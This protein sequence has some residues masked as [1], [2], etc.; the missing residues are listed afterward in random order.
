MRIGFKLRA[1]AVDKAEVNADRLLF[2]IK[3]IT[4]FSV[5]IRTDSPINN[6]VAR[7]KIRC[8]KQT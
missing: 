6:N 8:Q 3:L 1:L 4:Y 2:W 5:S 7:G